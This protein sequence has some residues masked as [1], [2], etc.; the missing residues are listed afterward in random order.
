MEVSV[1][2]KKGSIRQLF[3]FRNYTILLAANFISRFGDSLDAIA[4]SWMVYVLTGS[5]LMLG[6]LFAVNAIP[7]IVFG[8]F[9]GVIADRFDKKRLIIVGYMGRG[10]VVS[11]T[12]LM[13][14][15]GILQ[16]W[17]L[18]VF[19]II[20][21]TFETLTAPVFI[22]LV[23]VLVSKE[24][25]LSA[26]SFSTS[27]YKFAE[28]IGA[29]AAGA[30]I[31]LT[32]VSGAIFIDGSTFFAAVLIILF[33]KIEKD[34]GELEKIDAKG[35]LN[36]LKEGFSFI[37]SNHLIKTGIILMAILNFCLSPIN[38]LMPAFVNEQLK[39]GAEILSL[40]GVALS[41]GIILGGIVVGQIGQ[42]FKNSTLISFG[43][44][45]FGLNYCMMYL[46]GNIVPA[47][48]AATAIAAAN[49]FIFGFIIPM[50][51]SPITTSV[52]LN[53]EKSMMGRVGAIIGMVAMCA[54]PLGSAII[55]AICEKLSMSTIFAIMG[56][57]IALLGI[58]TMCDKELK[59]S[60]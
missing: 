29:G 37:K 58:K 7:N 46:P 34:T 39:G 38:V 35:Y 20:N 11:I 9:A 3:A 40:L 54:V 13:F 41:V 17:H 27:A 21:S 16:P 22:S 8:P 18:F 2:S 15:T 43:L 19:T 45:F 36:Q 23:P 50:I 53:T 51:S 55:G 31:A 6:T 59:E 42:K 1:E 10:I 52:M 28:L 4:Y 48:M 60:A 47:G 25:Y 5:K 56:G 49:F 14:F 32:G 57:I 44:L 24:F 30:I 12:A 26:N 33:I